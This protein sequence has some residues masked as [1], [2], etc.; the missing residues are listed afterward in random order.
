MNF[1]Q[2]YLLTGS[3][4]GDSPAY[5]KQAFETI[6]AKVGPIIQASSLYK[7]APWGNTEQQD[8]YNQVLGVETNLTAEEVLHAVLIIEQEMGRERHVKWA[9]R[10][11][12]IDVLFYNNAVINEPELNVPHPLLHKR[13]FTLEPLNEIAPQLVHPVFDK[14]INTL[15]AECEDHSVVE[16]L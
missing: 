8:F 16:K 6:S 1:N 13:R 14:S 3:N 9:P 5:L 10:T 7:T 15:L 12:D 4:I 11:I 2:V